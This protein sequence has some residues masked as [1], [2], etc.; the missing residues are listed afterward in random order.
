MTDAGGGPRIEEIRGAAHTGPGAQH[1]HFYGSDQPPMARPKVDPWR[2][3]LE[4]R[5][6]LKQRFVAPAGFGD[7]QQRLARVGTTVLLAGPAGSGRRTAAVMLLHGP[8]DEDTPFIEMSFSMDKE[9]DDVPDPEE[10]DRLLLDLSAVSE[11]AYPRAQELLYSFWGKVEAANAR[12]VAVLPSSDEELLHP[13]LRQLVAAIGRPRAMAVLRRH[14]DC[15]RIHWEPGALEEGELRALD[16]FAMRDIQRFANLV[17]QA[18]T[19][20]PSGAMAGWIRQALGALGNRGA[21]VTKEVA[22]LD[23]GPQRALL[24]VAAMMAGA[25]ADAVFLHTDRLLRLVEHTPDEKPQLERADL[26]ERLKALPVEVDGHGRI[27]FTSLAYDG[28]VRAHFWTYFPGLRDRFGAWVEDAVDKPHPALGLQER[29]RLVERFTEQSLRT[30]EWPLLHRLAGEWAA[31]PHRANE[32]MAVLELGL[33]HE[34]HAAGFRAKIYEWATPA[35]PV[36]PN[37]ARVLARACGEVMARTHPDQALVRLHHL[38]RRTRGSSEAD[39][40]EALFEL[41]RHDRRLYAKLLARLW[42]GLESRR[43]ATPDIRLFLGLVNPPPTS[44]VPSDA[45]TRG[46]AGVLAAVP[47]HWWE[48]TVG[49]WLSAAAS[50]PG[51][52][53][54]RLMKVLVSAAWGRV[55][56]LSRLYLVARDWAAAGG[57]PEEQIGRA[58]VA[59]RFWQ[60]I[61]SAQ[62]IELSDPPRVGRIEERYR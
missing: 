54:R 22:A 48:P 12:L 34:R 7:A 25:P 26:A 13:R 11:E 53:A 44:W 18:R 36:Q 62:G 16:T 59:A 57:Q 5:S 49:Q 45:L 51:P 1:N 3:A 10:G 39:V 55:D 38:A 61:D 29:R 60:E 43:D 33:T 30:S 56:L 52:T 6:W 37:L 9:N 28:A 17:A 40:R 20:D 23:S 46:W 42:D 32:A 21:E 4:Q 8:D 15:D 14:L 19:A 58:D 41:A 50:A 2:V 47:P 31:D 24:F 35:G 27:R